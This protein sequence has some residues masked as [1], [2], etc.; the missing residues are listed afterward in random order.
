MD[1]SKKAGVI[2]W[3][4]NHSRSP[5]I[6]GYWLKTYALKGAYEAIS[7]SPE[8][9]DAFFKNFSKSGYCGANI[10]IPHKETV[11]AHVDHLD[12]AAKAIGAVNTIWM[13]GDKLHGS[14]TDWLGFLG[15]LDAAHPGWD[16]KAESALVLGAG[17]AARGIIYAL[18]SRG[19]KQIHVANR[20]VE[21]A[22]DMKRH[23]GASVIP[24]ALGDSN[25]LV[26]ASDLIVNTTSLGMDNNPPLPL[27]LETASQECLVTDIVYSPLKTPLLLRAEEHGVKSVDGLGMLLHQA[28]PGFERWFGVAPKV[29]DEL[30]ALVLHDM[31]LGQ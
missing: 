27:S 11:M 4:V 22:H 18:I 15:S 29:S 5:L 24:H 20:T 3:P 2:G 1:K 10:T 12:D 28:A 13:E 26:G 19:F 14:N 17:G 16:R 7:V 9:A 21:R 31:G 23:F 25:N 6:H 8:E 30:R